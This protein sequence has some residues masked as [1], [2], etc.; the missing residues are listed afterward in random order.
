M[1]WTISSAAP[2]PDFSYGVPVLM[3][4]GGDTRGGSEGEHAQPARVSAGAVMPGLAW[5]Q[6]VGY[7]GFGCS[8]WSARGCGQPQMGE[9]ELVLIGA[10]RGHR[11]LDAAH[12]DPDEGADLQELQADG[13]AGGLGELG[14]LEGDAT[15]RAQQHV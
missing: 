7:V 13:A 4:I 15:Q 14:V 8:G 6:R 5:G 9:G 2:S 3:A 12:A 10:G 11:E 1:R